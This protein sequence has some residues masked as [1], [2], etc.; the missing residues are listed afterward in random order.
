MDTPKMKFIYKIIK[1][2]NQGI[3]SN[4]LQKVDIV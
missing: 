2:T 3:D 4:F 1:N